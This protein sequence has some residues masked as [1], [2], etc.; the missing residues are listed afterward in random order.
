MSAFTEPTQNGFTRRSETHTICIFCC[1]SI[2]APTP[3]ILELEESD[4]CEV[5]PV[6]PRQPSAR[7]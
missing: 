1:L 4:H 6:Y 2:R 7:F 3:A 5:C